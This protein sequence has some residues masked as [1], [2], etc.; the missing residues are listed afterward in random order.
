MCV[1]VYAC[2]YLYA[3]VCALSNC[4]NV[5]MD[6]YVH[7]RENVCMDVYVHVRKYVCMS[8]GLHEYTCLYVWVS[9]STC[10]GT[11][12]YMYLFIGVYEHRCVYGGMEL[13]EYACVLIIFMDVCV[14]INVY[15]V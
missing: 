10:T 8:V 3:H 6:V 11:L 13:C 7:V 4:R 2:D 9:V 14:T 5:Y 15:M 1:C 12:L